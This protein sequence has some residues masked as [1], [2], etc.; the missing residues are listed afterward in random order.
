MEVIQFEKGS[1]TYAS[2]CSTSCPPL[3]AI[4][5]RSGWILGVPSIYIQYEA[6]GDQ[7]VGRTVSGLNGNSCDIVIIDILK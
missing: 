2:S 1:I 6:S 7:Y 5:T 4:F 3:T